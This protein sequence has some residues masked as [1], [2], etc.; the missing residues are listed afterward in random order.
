MDAFRIRRVAS[1]FASVAIVLLTGEVCHRLPHINQA[2]V[3][4]ALLLVLELI[5]VNMGFVETLAAAVAAA[6]ELG[7]FFG[8]AHRWHGADAL[9]WVVTLAM[10]V[11]VAAITI[12]R[13][14][15]V[16]S[17]EGR[18]GQLVR[19]ID[20]RLGL[21][22]ERAGAM[23]EPVEAAIRSAELSSAML[24]S[25]VHDLKTPL[26][27]MNVALSSLVS[28]E[29]DSSSAR[30]PFLEMLEEELV[31]F[32]KVIGQL[33]HMGRLEN[34]LLRPVRQPQEVQPLITSILDE[35]GQTLRGR[36]VGLKIPGDTPAIFADFHLMKHVLKQLV[37]NAVKYTPAGTPLSI[38]SEQS[39]GMVTI[40]VADYGPG[41][42]EMEREFIFEKYYRGQSCREKKEGLGLGLAIAQSIVKAHGGQIWVTPNKACGSV[43]HFA[44]PTPGLVAR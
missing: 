26:A 35:M 27:T 22:M 24:D 4:L 10:F 33:L 34:G 7:Y 28:M 44:V 20:C 17:P 15:A 40:A 25:M 8:W 12:R 32:D 43:F 18:E 3:A 23:E 1:G 9:E 41:I 36:Q 19:A 5:A 11:A 39:N 13:N 21:S 29:A 42:P 16:L 31:H 2:A 37:E 14:H 6:L 38:F 30:G